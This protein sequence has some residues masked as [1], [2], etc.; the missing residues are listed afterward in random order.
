MK[1]K[2]IQFG[3]MKSLLGIVSEPDILADIGRK[4][5]ILILNSGLIHRIGPY[6][7]SVELARKLASA[8]FLVFRFDLPGIG[9][10]LVNDS[11]QGYQQRII[12]DIS[13]AMDAISQHYPVNKFVSLGNCTGAMN[14]HVI[15]VNDERVCGAVLMD[16]YMYPTLKYWLVRLK[17]KLKKLL[18]SVGSAT[19]LIL[20]SKQQ[21]E[22]Q[23]IDKNSNKAVLIREGVDYWHLPSKQ[24]IENDL[25]ELMNKD[26]Q[27]LYVFS[28]GLRYFYNHKEQHRTTFNKVDF[29]NNL[30][31]H[32]LE[33]MDHT[34]T[35]I[36][37][38]MFLIDLIA[39]W[40]SKNFNSVESNV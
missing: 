8:G 25:K 11:K 37:D 40:M 20:S 33:K 9:D 31:V 39:S 30:E 27:L 7:M 29:K 3:S 12:N 1:E 14:S 21:S 28:G 24:A 38:R 13:S 34:Y 19:L 2:F 36:R 26:V 23:I 5:A 22:N 10:S 32:F 4:P 18:G 15:A 16:T 35:L 6:R 17:D